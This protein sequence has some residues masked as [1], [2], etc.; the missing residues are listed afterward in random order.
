M[1]K[2]ITTRIGDVF[3]VVI[4]NLYKSY[5]QYIANDSS[6]LNSCV[7]RIF[8]TRYPIEYI[9]N[10]KDIVVDDVICYAHTFIKIGLQMNIWDRV[11]NC[12]ISYDI[13]TE[14]ILFGVA[15]ETI[16]NMSNI[17]VSYVNPLTNW[18][19]WAIS[20]SSRHYVKLPDCL[21]NM[22]ELGRVM[23][24]D[25]IIN[26]IEFG[27]YKCTAFEYDIIKRKPFPFVD[28][29][30]K[31]SIEN[32]ARYYHFHGEE[33]VREI[34]IENGNTYLMSKVHPQNDIF[35]MRTKVFSDTNWKY[36]EFIEE[37]EFEN[38]WQANLVK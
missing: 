37:D 36:N 21:I 29:Y 10:I 23:P 19:I 17:S 4:N 5:F 32:V 12:K 34:R 3:C 22:I 7:I 24:Y 38:I 15:Q 25:E 9:P 28:S 26:R 35:K 14:K 31:Q 33:P 30:V 1:Q 20:N 2:R 6:Q 16:V 11:G 8:K 13:N 27:Y 18:Y